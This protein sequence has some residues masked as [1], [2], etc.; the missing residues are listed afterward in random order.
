MKTTMSASAGPARMP[1]T[2]RKVVGTKKPER[3]EMAQQTMM[4]PISPVSRLRPM[5]ALGLALPRR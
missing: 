5:R 2:L 4:T 3:S 1:S